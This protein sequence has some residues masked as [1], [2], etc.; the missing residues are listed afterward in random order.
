[1]LGEFNNVVRQRAVL[2]RDRKF[3]GLFYLAKRTSKTYCRPSCATPHP[4]QKNYFFF[5][6]IE[7]AKLSG[8]H[9]CK[10][11][12]PDRLKYDLS[13][14]ILGSIDAGVI[15]DKGVHGLADSLHISERH[16]RRVV[17]DRT[18][19]TP[20]HLNQMKRLGAARRLITQTKLPVI[21]VA[22][23]TGFSSLRQ[24][25]DA[26]KEAFRTSPSQMRKLPFKHPTKPLANV[27]IEE[28]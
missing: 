1:M 20:T 12:Y 25:N 14:A 10:H 27:K 6:S 22:F 13:L 7:K 15:D 4:A 28:S 21:D 18:G 23:N 26:F 2:E 24:F 11:C 5:D 19:T 16:L 3:D 8:Y 9:A 17:K